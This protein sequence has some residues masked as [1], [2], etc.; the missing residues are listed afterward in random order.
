MVTLSQDHKDVWYQLVFTPSRGDITTVTIVDDISE[1]GWLEAEILPV[2]AE[3]KPNPGTI[4]YAD[5]IEV[6]EEGWGDLERCTD[7]D[8]KED[9]EPEH[10]YNRD[11]NNRRGIELVRVDDEVIITY[12]ARVES[13]LTDDICKRG[14][15]CEEKYVNK[16]EA[17][18]TEVDGEPYDEDLVSNQIEIQIFC[19]YILTRAAGDIFLERDLSYGVDIQQCSEFKSTPGVIIVPDQPDKPSIVSTGQGD[20]TIFTISHELCTA[21]ITGELTGGLKDAYGQDVAPRLSGQIC[22]VKL[23]TGEAWKQEFITN[24]I[25]ENKTRLS[26]WGYDYQKR[27]TNIT[28]IT[29]DPSNDSKSIFHIK[30]DLKI[31]SPQTFSDGDGAKTFII[32]GDLIIND[33][34][35]YGACP[36]TETCTVRDTASLAF[37][38]LG[39]SVYI[40]PNVSEIAGVYFVQESEGDATTGKLYSG[41]PGKFDQNSNVSLKV[42]GSVYG[43][44]D[45][46][47]GNRI[48]A[49]DPTKDEGGIVIRF[50]ERIIINT[51]PG[52]RDVLNLSQTEVAR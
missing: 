41:A 34:I 1:R 29:I 51:P 22:E 37:I 20:A 42:Y 16:A 25:D 17:E 31:N 3:G 26:R 27:E 21:G 24:S 18:I 38:V 11:I 2:D 46:L 40:D 43:D 5:T 23:R 15:V 50:D 47:F 14:Q 35:K 45:P 32:E 8:W 39:G 36:P 9:E 10:G 30:G 6:F 48:F 4:T 13:G 12:R 33:N 44:I 19:Q 28:E 7:V 52:L 49:G